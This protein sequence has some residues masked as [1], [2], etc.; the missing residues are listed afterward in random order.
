MVEM[1]SNLRYHGNLPHG[2]CVGTSMDHGDEVNL[3]YTLFRSSPVSENIY[4]TGGQNLKK[5]IKP[6]VS[7]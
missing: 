3:Y 2:S 1:G 7:T 6:R 5:N 4:S